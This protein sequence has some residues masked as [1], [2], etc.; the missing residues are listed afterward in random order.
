MA[1][2]LENGSLQ[3]DHQY[4]YQVQT[5]MF[6]CDIELADFV[7][8]TF[9]NDTATINVEQICADEDFLVESIVQAGQFYTVAMLPELLGKWYTR[10]DIMPS[11]AVNDSGSQ[12]HNY[13]YCKA[14][15]GGTMICYENDEC[16]QGQW[17]H[18]T[19]LK[20]KSAPHC[21]KWHCPYCRKLQTK[22]KL[23]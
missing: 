8:C 10:S 18:L 20:L 11:A 5:Q 21:K 19:C 9:P 23:K 22:H 1:K 15:L 12:E 2:F 14:E 16:S 17:F 7:V 6:V 13:C 4:Y 3:R